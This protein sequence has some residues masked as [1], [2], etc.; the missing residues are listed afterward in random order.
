MSR[1]LIRRDADA[2]RRGL[3]ERGD[4]VVARHT[5]LCEH[6]QRSFL[7]STA[8]V[9]V[10]CPTRVCELSTCPSVAFRCTVRCK[11][12]K[13]RVK[14]REPVPAYAMADADRDS[15]LGDDSPVVSCLLF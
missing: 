15:D 3:V 8:R 6:T 2:L 14:N 7:A 12:A 4:R 13:I 11:A 1:G 9:P 5:I 10:V